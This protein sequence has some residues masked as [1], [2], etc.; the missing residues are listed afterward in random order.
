M[1]KLKKGTAI[2]HIEV[3][4]RGPAR[5]MNNVAKEPKQINFIDY[6]GTLRYSYTAKEFTALSDM[7]ANPTHEKLL[8]QGWNWTREEILAQL[9]AVPDGKVWVGQMYITKSGA[10]EIDFFLNNPDL[11]TPYIR[12]NIDGTATLD[13]G[14][15]SPTET[16]T[17]TS[18]GES[19]YAHHTY[20]SVGEYT[21][22]LNVISGTGR[23]FNGYILSNTDS[24]PNTA[25]RYSTTISFIRI[26]NNTLID[27]YAF[28]GC[29][30][31][32][33]VTIA[34][35]VESVGKAFDSILSLRSLTLPHN[36]TTLAMH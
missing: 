30:K 22:S 18:I 32:E 19:K 33:Y 36:I 29:T 28:S 7:P 20:A 10:T 3:D 31:L 27:N 15:G 5:L 6:D 8:G 2:P 9:A 34:S 11:L 35:G 4:V 26:G 24:T 1:I 23:L 13:W 12:I 17:G 25:R 16:I 14:D 21:I